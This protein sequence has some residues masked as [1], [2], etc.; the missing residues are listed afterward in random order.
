MERLARTASLG[1]PVNQV[2]YK[3]IAKEIQT[4][5]KKTVSKLAREMI[6]KGSY[7]EN[8]LVEKA[9]E[10]VSGR[11]VEELKRLSVE[12]FDLDSKLNDGWQ[13]VHEALDALKGGTIYGPEIPLLSGHFRHW[14]TGWERIFN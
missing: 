9:F 3:P 6:N 8:R 4:K 7:N 5:A 10:R 11:S 2:V 14:R 13:A 1:S 12:E